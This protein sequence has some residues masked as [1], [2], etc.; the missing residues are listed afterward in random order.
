MTLVPTKPL[1]LCRACVLEQT[2]V[3][4]MENKG[5]I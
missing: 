4:G 1:I 2:S 3:Q 5:I